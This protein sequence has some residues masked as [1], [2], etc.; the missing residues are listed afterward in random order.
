MV[1]TIIAVPFFVTIIGASS[2]EGMQA[3]H[4]SEPFIPTI[5]AKIKGI[6]PD[7]DDVKSCYRTIVAL[8]RTNNMTVAECMH[9]VAQTKKDEIV[10]TL[11]G[12]RITDKVLNAVMMIERQLKKSLDQEIE[13]KNRSGIGLN[14]YFDPT[15]DGDLMEQITAALVKTPLQ[16]R[17]TF[18]LSSTMRNNF[19]VRSDYKYHLTSEKASSVLAHAIT[20]RDQLVRNQAKE[21]VGC[22]LEQLFFQLHEDPIFGFQ[23]HLIKEFIIAKLKEEG[24]WQIADTDEL[25]SSS[26]DEEGESDLLTNGVIKTQQVEDQ[27]LI[28]SNYEGD[29][30]MMLKDRQSGMKL[31]SVLQ[32]GDTVC[33]KKPEELPNFGSRIT[34][35]KKVAGL[36][37]AE[38][39]YESEKSVQAKRHWYVYLKSKND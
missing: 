24:V 20:I 23:P 14:A 15:I 37:E 34:W 22:L 33:G 13:L 32:R 38:E 3:L 30:G 26:S 7:A 19:I 1:R 39:L 11:K 16:R 31:I 29:W 36:C 25:S 12:G 2:L 18:N 28:M 5:M 6:N 10:A 9:K 21:D 17:V 4:E 27:I 8:L 35:L